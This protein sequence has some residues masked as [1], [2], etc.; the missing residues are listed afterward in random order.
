VPHQIRKFLYPSFIMIFIGLFAWAFHPNGGIESLIISPTVLT[1]SQRAFRIFQ[2]ISSVGG[3]WGG[4][5]ER[6]EKK[7]TAM[8]ALAIT[9]PELLQLPPCPEP[10]SP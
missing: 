3:T 9:L 1:K 10:S 8:P 4:T 5:G 7:N 2:C 6:F